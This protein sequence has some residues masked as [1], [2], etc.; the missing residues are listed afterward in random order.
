MLLH[1]IVGGHVLLRDKGSR[2]TAVHLYT[3]PNKKEEKK[4]RWRSASCHVSQSYLTIERREK[5]KR[6]K[7]ARCLVHAVKTTSWTYL[8]VHEP[9]ENVV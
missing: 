8:Y 2:R 6:I 9:R 5:R 4:K 1:I 7:R 3:S